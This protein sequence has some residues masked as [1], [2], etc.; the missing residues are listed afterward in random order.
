MTDPAA[1]RLLVAARVGPVRLIDNCAALRAADATEAVPP[2]R[3]V[4]PP[5]SAHAN[6][7]GSAE[8]CAAA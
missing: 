8:R 7:K 2:A 4:R 6:W 1:A 5:R 3:A